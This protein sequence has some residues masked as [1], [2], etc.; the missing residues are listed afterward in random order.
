MRL[1]SAA[2]E[3]V[4]AY[5]RWL[6][7]RVELI[8]V[9]GSEPIVFANYAQRFGGGIVH[10]APDLDVR[11]CLNGKVAGVI[12]GIRRA[13][14]EHVVIA[15]D[16]VRYDAPA[17]AAVVAALDSAD[18]V[19]PQNYFAPLPWHATLDSARTLL[20]RIS[21]GDWPGTLGVRR[22]RLLATNGYDGNVMFENLELVRTIKATGGVESIPLDL[23]VRRLPPTTEHFWSQR[24]RQ[25]YDEFARPSR[26]VVELAVLPTLVVGRG[27]AAVIIATL[28]IVAAEIG[29]RRA[30]GSTVF[31]RSAALWAPLWV[32]ERAITSWL[33][34][35]RRLSGGVRYSGG[36]LRDA[37]SSATELRRRLDATIAPPRRIAV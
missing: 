11:D 27:R 10:I 18:V 13:S 21:G 30:A 25:A 12:T 24:V 7:P 34:V 8:V 23:Y 2:S 4:V 9:D 36:T 17:L 26:Q 16:D 14:H 31:P 22:S 19:R 37:A 33:A 35:A 28:S 29:R 6:A 1:S 20:N 32:A 15:D 3:E 5:A